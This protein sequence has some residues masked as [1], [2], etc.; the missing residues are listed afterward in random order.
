MLTLSRAF[1]VLKA[2]RFLDFALSY[3]ALGAT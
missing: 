2:N 3:Q 1:Y